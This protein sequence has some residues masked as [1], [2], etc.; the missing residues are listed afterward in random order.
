MWMKENMKRKPEDDH[1][2]SK[3]YIYGDYWKSRK[4]ISWISHKNQF[5]IDDSEV[6]GGFNPT[7]IVSWLEIWIW[8]SKEKKVLRHYRVSV[9]KRNVKPTFE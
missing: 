6:E 4:E 1:W 2:Q 7:L 5:L 3:Y 8:K 9:V